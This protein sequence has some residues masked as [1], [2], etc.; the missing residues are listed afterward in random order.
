MCLCLPIVSLKKKHGGGDRRYCCIEFGCLSGHSR[1]SEGVNC[2]W[3]GNICPWGRSRCVA[4]LLGGCAGDWSCSSAAI[5]WWTCVSH[6]LTLL[7][8]SLWCSICIGNLS[9]HNGKEG[10]R[11][12]RLHFYYFKIIIIFIYCRVHLLPLSTANGDQMLLQR[13]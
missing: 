3:V 10:N 11:F 7:I 9:I 6:E 4:H 13:K 12:D 1:A 2:I 8:C 5:S